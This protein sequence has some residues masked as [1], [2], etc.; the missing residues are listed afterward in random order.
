ML[1]I[2]QN[3][4]FA[5]YVTDKVLDSDF[6]SDIGATNSR[7][8]VFNNLVKRPTQVAYI[9]EHNQWVTQAV[10]S[11]TINNNSVTVTVIAYGFISTNYARVG[12][13]LV[14]R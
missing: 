12:G 5:T 9:P 2:S 14:Y 3:S 1:L 11:I 13:R 10:Q 4:N 6:V 7:T 8:I